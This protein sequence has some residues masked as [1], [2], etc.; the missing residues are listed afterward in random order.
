MSATSTYALLLKSNAI[1][2]GTVGLEKPVTV[3]PKTEMQTQ[4]APL[5]A[6]DSTLAR[7]GCYPVIT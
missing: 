3:R 4:Q 6:S 5:S 7:V 1:E 2:T